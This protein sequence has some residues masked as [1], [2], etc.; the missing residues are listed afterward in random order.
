MLPG[1][2]KQ[3]TCV[4]YV[5]VTA[6]CRQEGELFSLWLHDIPDVRLKAFLSESSAQKGKLDELMES[7]SA[8][9]RRHLYLLRKEK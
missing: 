1:I 9:D 3:L 7:L 8:D 6:V 2:L 5:P 4:S